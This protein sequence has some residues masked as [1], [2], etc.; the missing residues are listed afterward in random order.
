M[1]STM[2]ENSIE[3]NKKRTAVYSL[4]AVRLKAFLIK[5]LDSYVY[6]TLTDFAADF[7]PVHILPLIFFTGA[8]L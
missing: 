6:F 7:L 8:T 2:P 5:E 3:N 1:K 4:T